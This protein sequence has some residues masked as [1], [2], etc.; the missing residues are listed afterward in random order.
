M[1]NNSQSPLTGI[2]EEE[3]VIIDFGEHEGKSI[4]EISDTHPDFYQYLLTIKEK[5]EFMIRRAKDKSFRLY[6]TRH[7]Q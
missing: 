1:A 7:I 2:I 5:G 3:K 4:F 6:L